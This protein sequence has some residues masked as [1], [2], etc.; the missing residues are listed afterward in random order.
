MKLQK[1]AFYF[2]SK[3]RKTTE[4]TSIVVLLLFLKNGADLSFIHCNGKLG[5]VTSL[6]LNNKKTFQDGGRPRSWNNF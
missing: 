3:G 5:M 6:I 1:I 2:I 4:K